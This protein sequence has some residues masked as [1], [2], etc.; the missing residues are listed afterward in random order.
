MTPEEQLLE[1]KRYIDNAKDLLKNK[2]IKQ[3]T[4]YQDSK[5]VKMAG[6]TA[7]NGVLVALDIFV[8]KQ[9]GRKSVDTYRDEL[10]KMDNSILNHFNSA[11]N[12]LH[13]CLGYDGETSY[14]VV[15]DGL[16]KANKIIEF[17]ETRIQTL[18]GVPKTKKRTTQK[19]KTT[20]KKTTS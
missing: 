7:W 9:K 2:A 3:G 15:Q 6:N 5:Y 4:H 10:R 19:T 1:A 8:K 12:I 20:F 17:V 13:L 18:Q 14:N 16:R 11:Y